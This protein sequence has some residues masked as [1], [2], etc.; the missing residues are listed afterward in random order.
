MINYLIRVNHTSN[1]HRIKIYDAK[2][3]FSWLTTDFFSFPQE[4]FFLLVE[5]ILVVRKKMFVTISRKHF[6]Y[7][8]KHL[9]EWNY[10]RSHSTIDNLGLHTAPKYA[11]NLESRTGICHAEHWKVRLIY[12]RAIRICLF[13]RIRP[14]RFKGCRTENFRSSLQ[15]SYNYCYFENSMALFMI[16]ITEPL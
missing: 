11:R 10:N 12:F 3:M 9:W 15:R 4:S 1:S 6:I 16:F 7:I 14:R 8:R 5:K 13:S 2:K